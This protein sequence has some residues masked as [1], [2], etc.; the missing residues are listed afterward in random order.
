M[1]GSDKMMSKYKP[2]TGKCKYMLDNEF[3]LGCNRLEDP[4]FIR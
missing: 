3:C 2:I 4:E 1:V